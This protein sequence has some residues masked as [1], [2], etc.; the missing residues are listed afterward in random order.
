MP[1]PPRADEAF[2]IY[3]ALNRANLRATIFQKEGDHI[4][5]EKILIGDGVPYGVASET[6]A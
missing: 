3:H 2:G 4:A 1:R 5:F 6:R